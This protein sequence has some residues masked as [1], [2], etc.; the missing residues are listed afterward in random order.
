GSGRDFLSGNGGVI[1]LT[2]SNYVVCSP[3]WNDDRGAATFGSGTTGVAGGV[4][5]GESLG[6]SPPGDQG[7]GA[8]AVP[9]ANGNYVVN[10]P[11]WDRGDVKDAGAATLG[12][13]STGVVGEISSANSLVG[14]AEGDKVGS[15]SSV[16]LTNGNYV[17]DSPN[18]SNGPI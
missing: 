5:A 16:A 6:G 17:V 13:G 4:G 15:R 18:W 9:L 2:N 1:I 10:S 8:S 14:S 11:R 12:D 7:C 3:L